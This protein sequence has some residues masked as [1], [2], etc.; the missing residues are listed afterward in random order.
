MK[1]RLGLSQGLIVVT[2]L[3]HKAVQTEAVVQGSRQ[4][5]APHVVPGL[6]AGFCCYPATFGQQLPGWC[7]VQLSCAAGLQS[8]LI[9]F[10]I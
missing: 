2:V 9:P 4:A 8:T 1:N 10:V 6:S 5:A 7:L 3:C